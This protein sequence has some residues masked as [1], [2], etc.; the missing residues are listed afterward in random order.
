MI[1]HALLIGINHYRVEDGAFRDLQG[2]LNDVEL[3]KTTLVTTGACAPDRFEVLTDA[4]ATFTNV[5]A[6][7]SRWL[8]RAA[9]GER[10]FLYYSGH[11]TQVPDTDGDEDEMDEAFVLHDFSKTNALVDDILRAF[12]ARVPD[13]A[14][15][16][17]VLDCCHSGGLARAKDV[18]PRGGDPIPRSAYTPAELKML[19]EIQKPFEIEARPE[20]LVML[21]AA[22]Q[23]EL[24]WEK[25]LGGQRH[26]CFTYALCDVLKS[27]GLQARARDVMDAT[28]KTIDTLPGPRFFQVP[29]L[30]GKEDLFDAPLFA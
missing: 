19:G 28:V 20:R 2:C 23:D 24:A 22:Q 9:R 1:S 12:F 26:G 29:R 3:M 7:L 11:G 10:L 13:E 30:V 21:A 25:K 15:A 5:T 14:Q 8:T 6:A 18:Q 27:N 16:T 4:E 17:V